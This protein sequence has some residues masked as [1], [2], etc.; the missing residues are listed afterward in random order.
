MI[1]KMSEA[2][3]LGVD[4]DILVKKDAFKEF[5]RKRK[6]YLDIRIFQSDV[7]FLYSRCTKWYL[8]TSLLEEDEDKVMIEGKKIKDKLD[9]I[10]DSNKPFSQVKGYWLIEP[11]EDMLAVFGSEN[12]VA[13]SDAINP[14]RMEKLESEYYSLQSLYYWDMKAYKRKGENVYDDKHVVAWRKVLKDF[15]K[16]DGKKKL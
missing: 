13:V 6:L 11:L 14:K 10:I 5:F 12:V 1:E 2:I 7:Y 9:S 16:N 8:L 4:Y 3:N 15:I